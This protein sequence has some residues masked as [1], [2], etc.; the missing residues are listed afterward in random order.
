MSNFSL[1]GHSPRERL[2]DGRLR[3]GLLDL[4]VFWSNKNV[5]PFFVEEVTP[6]LLSHLLEYVGV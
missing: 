1:V 6:I 3:V 4:L 2:L 5:S